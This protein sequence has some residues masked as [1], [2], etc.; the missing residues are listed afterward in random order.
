MDDEERIG[1]IFIPNDLQKLVLHADLN[2]KTP[3]PSP[4]KTLRLPAPSPKKISQDLPSTSGGSRP[5]LRSGDPLAMIQQLSDLN[6]KVVILTTKIEEQNNHIS[7]MQSD[8]HRMVDLLVTMVDIFKAEDPAKA[9]PVE[10]KDDEVDPAAAV[11]PAQVDLTGKSD[12]EGDAAVHK[13]ES[14]DD[15]DDE[16]NE[17]DAKDAE[18]SASDDEDRDY[19]PGE[20]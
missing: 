12:D 17:S 2:W 1:R 20:Y 14:D 13:I 6:D 3:P 16:A 5:G 10:K 11:D 15:D 4:E 18:K 8:V 9:D 19:S 7:A